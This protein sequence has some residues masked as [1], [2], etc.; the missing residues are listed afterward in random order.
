MQR[1]ESKPAAVVATN[2]AIVVGSMLNQL[3]KSEKHGAFFCGQDAAMRQLVR[4]VGGSSHGTISSPM[5]LAPRACRS[6]DRAM[7]GGVDQ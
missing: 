2:T 7:Q 5:Q 4:L 3:I 6:V 1:P